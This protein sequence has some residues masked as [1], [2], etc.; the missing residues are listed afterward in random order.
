[1]EK[2]IFK[3]NAMASCLEAEYIVLLTKKNVFNP[4]FW[5]KLQLCLRFW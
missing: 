2:S 4:C 3:V 1:M 5:S